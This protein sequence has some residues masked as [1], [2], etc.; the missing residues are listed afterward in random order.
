MLQRVQS[1]YLLV[2]IVSYV[3]LFFFP[4]AEF[5]V[6]NTEYYFSLLKVS[7]GNSNRDRKSVV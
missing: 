4:F 2:V 1:L 6:N 3:L 5:T 7:N